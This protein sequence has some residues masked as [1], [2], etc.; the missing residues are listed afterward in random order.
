VRV[1]LAVVAPRE[2]AVVGLGGRRFLMSE[3]SL[4][5]G[6]GGFLGA[7]HP[8]K[9]PREVSHVRVRLAVIA[10]WEEAVVGDPAFDAHLPPNLTSRPN[11]CFSDL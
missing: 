9:G 5:R 4:S 7:R 6:G 11:R 1:R 8:C 10:P 3:V 2:E